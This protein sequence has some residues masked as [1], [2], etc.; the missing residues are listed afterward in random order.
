M[1]ILEQYWIYIFAVLILILTALWIKKIGFIRGFTSGLL[2]TVWL[3]PILLFLF[4]H[5][6]SI[7][8]A[9]SFETQKVSVF[10]DDSKSIGAPIKN[11]S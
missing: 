10:V 2:R 7:Q 11:V 9:R 4:P 1:L 6:K 5:E 8:Q 3:C